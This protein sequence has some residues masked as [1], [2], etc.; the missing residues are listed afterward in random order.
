MT[1]SPLFVMRVVS[2][3]K[4]IVE[5]GD[6]ELVNVVCNV[7]ESRVLLPVIGRVRMCAL[8]LTF[9]CHVFPLPSKQWRSSTSWEWNCH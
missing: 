1:V 3:D 6:N 9:E 7:G 5:V 8:G 2:G 4:F